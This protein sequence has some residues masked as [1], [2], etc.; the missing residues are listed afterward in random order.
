MR[1]SFLDDDCVLNTQRANRSAENS[2]ARCAVREREQRRKEA[3][4]F[5]G[6]AVEVAPT[7]AQE[8]PSRVGY[9][10]I[11]RQLRSLASQKARLDVEE[12]RW[13]REAERQRVW[14]KLG[15]STALEYLEEV[16]GYAPR[17][18][19]DKLRVANE[20]GVLPELEAAVRDGALP[21]SAAKELTRVM[22][23]DTQTAW[24][25]RA[26]GKT[27]G[28]IQRLVAGRKKGDEPDAPPDPELITRRLVVELPPRVDALLERMRHMFQTERGEHVDD[29]ALIEALCMR[30]IE[31]P[32][33][34]NANAN[35]NG[36]APRPVHRIVTYRCEDCA[37]AWREG[38]GRLVE[39][40][41]ADLERAACDAELVGAPAPAEWIDDAASECAGDGANEPGGERAGDGANEPGGERAGDGANEPGSER[42]G[43]GANEPGNERA[44]GG[45]NEPG[46]ERAGDVASD[47]ARR[48]AVRTK[49]R[50][51][52]TLTIPKATRDVVWARDQ[53]RCRVPGCRATR[54]L[55]CHHVVFQSQGGDHDPANLMVIC[56][57]HHTLLHDG[58]LVITGRA[59]DRLTFT[60]N[61]KPLVDARASSELEH[62]RR[63]RDDG[64]PAPSHA[65]ARH[66]RHD[67]VRRRRFDDVVKLEHAKQALMQLGF[68]AR[69]AKAAA[70]VACARVGSD[71]DIPTI[72]KAALQREPRSPADAVSAAAAVQSEAKQALRQLGYRAGVADTAVA[73]AV[74]DVGSAVD[75]ATLIKEALRR[76]GT[77]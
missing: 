53:G 21:W 36:K 72:V 44:G 63:L 60:R 30:A 12:A 39:V 68:K 49:R 55:E 64:E 75:L 34:A 37:R 67:P 66:G 52:P 8:E 18:A 20:L 71:A 25:A 58:L 15:Y 31:V 48:S 28:D 69:A 46:N 7:W 17:T 77:S 76:C 35:A 11:D 33:H 24:L 16:F 1:G 57:G 6:E 23:P 54:N 41:T 22:M 9:R 19:M 14:R 32:A 3:A 73:R 45:A 4:V 43:G 42:A 2:R 38:R 27:V 26:R 40:T 62:G 56:D 5:G 10:E 29:V 65:M 74:A 13:L 61:G 47:G 51:P 70:E 50:P 59:P